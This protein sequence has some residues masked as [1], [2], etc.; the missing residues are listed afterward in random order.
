[1]DND[2]DINDLGAAVIVNGKIV[3]WFADFDDEAR[4]WCS[5]NHFGE[6]MTWR[7]KI[8]EIVPL[9]QEE[10]ERAD[11]KAKEFAKFFLDDDN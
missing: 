5:Y 6:W 4:E 2:I 7:S 3:A 8:P 11:K 9:T 10:V 1:M